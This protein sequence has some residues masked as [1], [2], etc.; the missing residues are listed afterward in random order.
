MLSLPGT[1]M[2]QLLT[3]VLGF[4]G[5]GFC[6]NSQGIRYLGSCKIFSIDR[7][8]LGLCRDHVGIMAGRKWGAYNPYI[9]P[10][11]PLYTTF[12][13]SLLDPSKGFSLE[14]QWGTTPWFMTGAANV[15]AK[16]LFGGYHAFPDP[17]K[18]LKIRSPRSIGEI[19]QGLYR[20]YNGSI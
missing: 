7:N 15:E 9:I 19:I 20:G 2:A 16:P 6:H 18:D 17:Q 5:L 10:I 12:R 14:H 3:E 11:N 1:G 4:R 13:Y 8:I